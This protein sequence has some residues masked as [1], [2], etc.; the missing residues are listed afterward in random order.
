MVRPSFSP[1]YLSDKDKA[2]L[3]ATVPGAICRTLNKAEAFLC[4]I[5][6]R[7]L[8]HFPACGDLH[9]RFTRIPLDGCG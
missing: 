1:A 7:V 2:L 8:E 4:R 5:E 6:E 3:I 9:R